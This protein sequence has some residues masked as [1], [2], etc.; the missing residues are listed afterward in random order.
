MILDYT[1]L[2]ILGLLALVDAVWRRLPDWFLLVLLLIVLAL[3]LELHF[4]SAVASGFVV[5]VAGFPGGDIKGI[6][7]V[8]LTVSFPVA[9]VVLMGSFLLTLVLWAIRVRE[10]PWFPLPLWVYG[11][12][13]MLY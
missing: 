8:M 10:F 9:M 3:P 5:L 2:L 13:L 6:M 4:V 12:M 11:V 7:L 1:P